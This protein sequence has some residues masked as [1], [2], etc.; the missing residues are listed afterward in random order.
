[1]SQDSE[2]PSQDYVQA[3][4]PESG[5]TPSPTAKR[6]KP[7]LVVFAGINIALLA[8]NIGVGL[9]WKQATIRLVEKGME[10]ADRERKLEAAEK[11]IEQLAAQ[12]KRHAD[13]SE[14]NRVRSEAA[15]RETEKAQREIESSLARI[16]NIEKSMRH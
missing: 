2:V 11:E 8:L 14:A 9:S 7:W 3:S 5:P 4:P 16:K 12:T 13:E 15:L 6:A 1:M 10:L